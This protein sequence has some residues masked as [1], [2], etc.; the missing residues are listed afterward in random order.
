MFDCT[1]SNLHQILLSDIHKKISFPINIFFSFYCKISILILI[2]GL[3]VIEIRELLKPTIGATPCK[4][5]L[6]F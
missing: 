3:L 6:K 2:N 5:I 4:S 1:R